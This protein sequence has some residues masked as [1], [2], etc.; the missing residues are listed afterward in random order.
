MER[1]GQTV[2][3]SRAVRE[4]GG[5]RINLLIVLVVVGL[6]IYAGSNWIPVMF[7]SQAVKDEMANAVRL[8][9]TG[10]TPDWVKKQIEKS[11]RENGIEVKEAKILV[12]PIDGGGVQATVQYAR[13][14][15]TLP[16]YVYPY[17]FD[18]TAT[19]SGFLTK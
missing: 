7:Q 1:T 17:K 5:A 4:R 15:P 13:Q 8:S 19:T 16:G 18:Y 9:A 12:Q 14:V 2:R 11:L 6:S 3:N 10:Q